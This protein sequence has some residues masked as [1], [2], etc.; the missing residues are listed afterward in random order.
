MRTV[1]RTYDIYNY[2]ELTDE[3][4]GKARSWYLN[5]IF[6]PMEFENDY[7]EDLRYLFKNSS[8]NLQFSL[9]YCQ[10]DGLNIYG[11]LDLE[12]IF[13]VISD[14]SYCGELFKDFWDVLTEH[15][16]KTLRAYMDICGKY[17]QLPRNCRYSFCIADRTD[18]AGDWIEQLEYSHYRDI[19]T[20]IIFKLEKLVISIFSFLAKCYEEDGYKYLYEVDEDE[21]SEVCESNGWEF[22][23]DGRYFIE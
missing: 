11:Q 2:R 10:G 5:D 4:K 7:T 19:Q 3:A 8:L 15:Q 14:K 18:F 16:I 20:D 12:D 1:T 22:L 21:I 6:R 23:A 13:T 9:S 17:I